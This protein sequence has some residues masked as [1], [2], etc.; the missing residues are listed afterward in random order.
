LTYY[1]IGTEKEVLANVFTGNTSNSIG[2]EID[3]YIDQ[4]I[5]ERLTLRLVAAYLVADDAYT[6]FRHDDDAYKAGAVLSWK[7]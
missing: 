5:M 3:F 6:I 2:H 1:Y 4:D 7:F